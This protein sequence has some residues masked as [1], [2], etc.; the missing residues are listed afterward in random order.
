VPGRSLGGK[1][2]GVKVFYGRVMRVYSGD[3]SVGDKIQGVR[4]EIEMGDWPTWIK[5][6]C[7]IYEEREMV[8]VLFSS[9]EP[10][11]KYAANCVVV[12]VN[13]SSLGKRLQ[14]HY[15]VK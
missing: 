12:P 1:M 11:S 7:Y 6:R 10:E 8:Y 13:E 14:H 5:K 15:P 9:I 3:L 4:L 2:D